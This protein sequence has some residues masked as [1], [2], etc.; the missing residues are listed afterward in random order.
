[1][2]KTKVDSV[3]FFI[4]P[5]EHIIQQLESDYKREQKEKH[6]IYS[7]PHVVRPA[8]ESPVRN[9]RYMFMVC[10]D[11]KQGTAPQLLAAMGNCLAEIIATAEEANTMK[12]LARKIEQLV[13]D[14]VDMDI[15]CVPM[16]HVD[17]FCVQ[18]KQQ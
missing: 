11:K 6:T 16:E 9:Y 3:V 14:E 7:L 18:R 10:F 12:E 2:D 15:V 4:E 1:M 8:T 17:Y 5:K 13:M